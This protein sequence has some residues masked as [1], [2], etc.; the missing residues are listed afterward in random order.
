MLGYGG[1]G[2]AEV[3]LCS[4][5]KELLKSDKLSLEVCFGMGEGTIAEQIQKRGI[6]TY[7]LGMRN[8]LD[9]LNA[10]KLIRVIRQGDYDIIHSHG[11]QLL[12]SL[13]IA[14]ARPFVTILTEHGSIMVKEQGRK[15]LERYFH[16]WMS[17]YVDC[18]T[19]V[20]QA[21]KQMLMAKHHVS[22]GKIRVIYNATDL[23]RFCPLAV[24]LIEQRKKLEIPS[25]S[26]VIGTVSRLV[27]EHG[28]DHFILAASRILKHYPSCLFMIVGN[29]EIRSELEEQTKKLRISDKVIFL[30][31]REDVPELLSVM[32]V[33][34]VPSV[35][36]ALSVAAIEAMAMEKPIV[37]YA[38]G[39][40]PEVVV[41]KETGL[42]IERRAPELLAEGIVSLLKDRDER[43]K[44][45]KAGRKRVTEHFNIQ[46]IA[47]QY[48]NLYLRMFDQRVVS[49]NKRF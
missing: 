5:L 16:I 48:M 35:R 39:G 47:K 3:F 9:L 18:Y 29:G 38:V 49:Q 17:R 46:K 45:S 12:L 6:R 40:I 22:S 21:I 14:L 19:A 26:A 11:S 13:M 23:D 15:K 43:I 36:E 20:S 32:D 44:M 2:G 33:F 10:T 4:L 7:C 42:L 28:I 34:V 25:D 1:V 31:K 27:P 8:G 41:H 37:A 24:S 30:G